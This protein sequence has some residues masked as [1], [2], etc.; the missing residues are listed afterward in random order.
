MPSCRLT[1]GPVLAGVLFFA[2]ET[3]LAARRSRPNVEDAAFALNRAGFT[4][5]ELQ[6][7][8]AAR[9]HRP[10]VPLSYQA[11]LPEPEPVPLP[12]KPSRAELEARLPFQPDFFPPLPPEHSWKQTPVS[13]VVQIQKKAKS[14]ARCSPRA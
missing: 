4:F 3:A 1:A 7:F 2:H 5:E 10:E 9:D 14:T 13:F 11:P 8:Y 12:Y 6:A